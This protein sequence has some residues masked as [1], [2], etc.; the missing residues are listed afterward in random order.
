MNCV[1]NDNAEV[2]EEAMVAALAFVKA[3]DR[4]PPRSLAAGI[5]ARVRAR[6]VSDEEIAWKRANM[7]VYQRPRRA[8]HEDHAA[9]SRRSPRWSRSRQALPL[10][11]L[12]PPLGAEETAWLTP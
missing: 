2:G 1:V 6:A 9:R 11:E 3:E 8:Q 12:G 5:P 7:L 10:P 4:I